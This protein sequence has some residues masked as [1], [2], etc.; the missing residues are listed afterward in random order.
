MAR[1]V[2]KAPV[3]NWTILA[4]LKF[5]SVASVEAVKVVW[6][7]PVMVISVGDPVVAATGAKVNP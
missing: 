1:W 2:V 5:M 3:E 6:A 4:R 7:G